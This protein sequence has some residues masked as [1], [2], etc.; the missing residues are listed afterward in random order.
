MYM[1]YLLPTLHACEKNI[2]NRQCKPMI[3]FTLLL[4][5]VLRSIKK[6]MYDW[7]RKL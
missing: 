1:G 3:H 4:E 2:K 7:I 6:V 5:A